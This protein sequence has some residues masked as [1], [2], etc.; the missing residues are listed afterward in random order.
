[1]P[2]LIFR[3]EQ[4]FLDRYPNASIHTL[5]VEGVDR[6]DN[7]LVDKWKARAALVV[8]E[9]N[10]DPQRLVEE[11]WIAE[12][13]LAIRQM[14]LN[15]AKTRSSIEQLA[16]RALGGSLISTPI[17]SV[18]LYCAISTIARAPMGG[19]RRESLEGD[20]RVRLARE[21]ETFLGIGEKQP[22]SVPPGVVV[23]ADDEKIACYAWNHKDSGRTCLERDTKQAVFFADAV[24]F[25]G[26]ERATVGLEL[27]TEA[28]HSVGARVEFSGVLDKSNPTLS[29]VD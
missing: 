20:I 17:P 15:A 4:E 9:W 24:S 8:R 19:Y 11:E 22:L 3:L 2:K 14:G 28:L 13:R 21:S 6:V 1:M 29:W 12:W 26:R 18:N 25:A 16:K 23:Y 10:V 27:L 5:Y 7:A